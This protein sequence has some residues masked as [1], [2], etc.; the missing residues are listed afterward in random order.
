[1]LPDPLSRAF[2]RI[3]DF[4]RVQTANGGRITVDAVDLL[5][6]AV[7]IDPERRSIIAARVPALGND[8]S[9][10]AVLLGVLVGLFAAESKSP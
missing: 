8:L 2:D 3:D 4:V 7:G 1:M 5:Q 6:E 9:A 10:G